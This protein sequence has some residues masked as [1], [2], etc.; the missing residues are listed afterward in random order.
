MLGSEVY[1]KVKTP[2]LSG[3]VQS[4]HSL[5]I[6]FCLGNFEQVISSLKAWI[7]SFVRWVINTKVVRIIGSTGLAENLAYIGR[8]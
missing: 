8:L 4:N 6:F 2:L 5:L 7:S 3:S 1:R